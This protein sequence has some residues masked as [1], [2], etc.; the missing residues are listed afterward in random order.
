MMKRYEV[1]RSWIPG[2]GVGD[3]IGREPNASAEAVMNA[4]VARRVG[5]K[6]DIVGVVTLAVSYRQPNLH[7]ELQNTV[8]SWDYDDELHDRSLSYTGSTIFSGKVMVY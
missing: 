1:G 6:V 8:F 5:P 4:S 3:A 2:S 7:V